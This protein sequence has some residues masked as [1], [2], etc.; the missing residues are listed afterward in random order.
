MKR[1]DVTGGPKNSD[2]NPRNLF[3]P[4][5]AEVEIGSKVPRKSLLDYH[6]RWHVDS[7][8]KRLLVPKSDF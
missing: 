2:S 3:S 1:D 7:T 6:R 8:T 4:N 5:S